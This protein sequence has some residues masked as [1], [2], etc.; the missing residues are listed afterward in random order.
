M[1]EN[2]ENENNE[3]RKEIIS[4]DIRNERMKAKSNI[5]ENNDQWHISSA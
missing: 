1:K 2:E 5:S 4:K 3:R